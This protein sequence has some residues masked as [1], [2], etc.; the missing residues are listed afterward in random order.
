MFWTSEKTLSFLRDTSERASDS[1]YSNLRNE[2]QKLSVH[3]VTGGEW[4]ENINDE[5]VIR[6][7]LE[8]KSKPEQEK[9]HKQN[10]KSEQKKN[11]D[12]KQN[13]KEAC[14]YN[15]C[16]VRDLVRLIRN[17]MVHY[18][19]LTEDVQVLVIQKFV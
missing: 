13:K 8:Q 14:M 19:E 18:G 12:S 10:K 9:T 5:N 3:R 2:L 6:Y 11:S 16:S 4:D 1:K 15:F 7:I 17:M